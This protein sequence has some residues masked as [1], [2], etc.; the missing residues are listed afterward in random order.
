MKG[1]IWRS[2]EMVAMYFILPSFIG[3]LMFTGIPIIASLGLSFFSWNMLQPAEFIGFD[4]FVNMFSNDPVFLRVL[5]NTVLFVIGTVP[6]SI[7]I[8]LAIALLLNQKLKFVAFLRAAY[9]LP[10]ITSV[11]AVSMVWTWIFS[12]D[13]G[14][15]NEFLM[16]MGISDPPAW[17]SS[18]TWAL[19]AI[20]IVA[21]WKN[22]GFNMVIYLAGL[23]DIPKDLYESADL[24]GASKWQK[25]LYV[26]MPLL[27]PTTFFVTIMAII[28]SFQVFGFALMMTEGGPGIATNTLVLYIYQQGFNYFNM[29]YAS[30]MAWLLFIIIFSFTLLQTVYSKRRGG[31]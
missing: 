23:Q 16:R 20:I 2:N 3:F 7:G 28:N 18:T 14:F 4:N 6:F 26:T 19:P 10:V 15:L 1:S 24:D 5:L 21:I 31:F 30:A 27:R 12:P 13:Y 11:V 22:I 25:I 29:G 8:G 17:L 9:F